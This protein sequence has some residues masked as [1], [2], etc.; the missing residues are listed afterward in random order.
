MNSTRLPPN[1]GAQFVRPDLVPLSLRISS[2]AAPAIP[3]QRHPLELNN[4]DGVVTDWSELYLKELMVVLPVAGHVPPQLWPPF[5]TIFL[6]IDGG[7]GMHFTHNTQYV[8]QGSGASST[9]GI[10][11]I[12][13]VVNQERPG[14][15][16]LV[17]PR[18]HKNYHPPGQHLISQNGRRAHANLPSQLFLSIRTDTGAFLQATEV[19]M[20]FNVRVGHDV[21][22]L[23]YANLPDSMQQKL[24]SGI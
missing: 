20:L 24:L 1:A 2:G 9:P 13:N 15:A 10:P 6:E 12:V 7:S 3:I 11:V 14:S 19:I 8:T 21:T 22:G 18:I 16:A 5:S 23:I 4:I 17:F